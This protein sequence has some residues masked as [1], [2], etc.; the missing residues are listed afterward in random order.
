MNRAYQHLRRDDDAKW[1]FRRQGTTLIEM[2]VVM[3]LTATLLGLAIGWIHQSMALASSSRLRGRQERSL[4]RLT[5]QLRD[6]IHLA[7]SATLE[8]ETTLTLQLGPQISVRYIV[9]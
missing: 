5:N 4:Q 1:T 3:S 7:T 8:D 2:L 9:G 6:D